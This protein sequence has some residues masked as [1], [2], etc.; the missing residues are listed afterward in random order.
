[1]K[2]LFLPLFIFSL[3]FAAFSMEIE[4]NLPGTAIVTSETAG[5]FSEEANSKNEEI[6]SESQDSQNESQNENSVEIVEKTK[7]PPHMDIDFRL[8]LIPSLF[9][10]ITGTNSCVKFREDFSAV[11]K[12]FNFQLEERMSFADVNRFSF[13]FSLGSL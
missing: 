8:C 6:F 1:M 12:A 4:E 2:K 7:V 13:A 3:T 9:G 10:H 5:L 11:T